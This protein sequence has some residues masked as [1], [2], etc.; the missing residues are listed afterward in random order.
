MTQGAKRGV[1]T[2]A[3]EDE[4]LRSAMSVIRVCVVA[5]RGIY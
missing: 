2:R 1:T 5:G 4:E 3:T